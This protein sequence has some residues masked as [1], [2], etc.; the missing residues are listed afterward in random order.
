MTTRAG[1]RRTY[2]PI[3]V[4]GVI[5]PAQLEIT[6]YL[7]DPEY[8]VINL[9]APT[10]VARACLTLGHFDREAGVFLD[11]PHFHPW[12]LNRPK[13]SALPK[14]LLRA[15]PIPPEVCSRDLAFAWFLQEIGI[16]S[17]SWSLDWP[18]REGLL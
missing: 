11:V 18:I 16:E 13:G 2:L 6:V 17:P 4:E 12:K 5:S 1:E 9:L 14:E 3:A 10:C 7:H 15:I 8:L